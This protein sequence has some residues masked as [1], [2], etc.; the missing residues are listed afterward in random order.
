V[1]RALIALAAFWLVAVGVLLALLLARP[2]MAQDR[3]PDTVEAALHAAQLPR[4]AFAAVALPLGGR[5]S[6][7]GRARH[8]LPWR[9]RAEVPMQPASTM[10]LV[11]SVVALDRLGPNHRGH[12]VLRSAAPLD[13]DVLRGDLVMQGGLDPDLGLA[14]V[15]AL[16]GELRAAGVREIA[17]DL[18]VDRTLVYPPR[19]DLGVPAFDEAP[20]FAYNVIPDALQLAGALLP[21]EL[22][23]GT[24]GVR[25][26]TL[27]ALDGVVITSAMTLRDPNPGA[28]NPC[29]QW[30]R[31]WQRAVSRR[32]ADGT[33]HL[34]LRGAF[35]RGCT[36]RTAL[37]VMDR[38]WLTE[39]VFATLWRQWGGTWTGRAREAAAPDGTRVLA[40]REARAWG[41]ALRHLNKAS[42][43]AH[44]RMLYFAL[45]TARAQRLPAEATAADGTRLPT[46]RLA[47]REVL[48]WF[49]A[50][51]IN[52]DGLVMDNG[53]GLSRSER[54]SPMQMAR[55]L[56][57]A[58]AGRHAPDLWMSLPV[59]GTDGTL[60]NRLREGP[61]TGWARLKTGSLW[62][63][64]A[65]AGLVHDDDGR[66]WAVAMMVN[67][68]NAARS[69]PV[70]DAFVD[71]VARGGVHAPLMPVGPQ[72]HG[73]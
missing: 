71:W 67:H 55:M 50:H 29:T 31:D 13:G 54:I 16:L 11:T 61:A 14:E 51:G 38:Q 7:D 64:R 19:P 53:S 32:D 60:R 66:P 28:T 63:V 35:P 43:N 12:T 33:V 4:D 22:R 23:A 37:Q 6:G 68:P 39:R 18:I 10:K 69:L 17:G 45:G 8:G 40:R 41:E 59:A 2:A 15:W 27:P 26:R 56:Q 34:E 24:D 48:E 46:A 36:Q 47:E 9:H 5:E 49:S 62:N 65:L 58:N 73:P 44:T 25:V 42:D 21:L 57:V 52:P 20:E 70:L 30:S 1:R 72:D 3:L